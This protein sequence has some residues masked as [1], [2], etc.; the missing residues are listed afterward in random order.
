MAKENKA[1]INYFEVY[2][3]KK[4][5]KVRHLTGPSA[6]FERTV[7]EPIAKIWEARGQ[8]KIL[9]PAKVE[10]K[11]EPKPDKNE[12]LLRVA[13]ELGIKKADKMKEEELIE[14][15]ELAQAEK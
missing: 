4:L 8:V 3:S 9:G 5:M 1:D 13:A 12:E 14:A 15:I 7:K 10:P 6:G 11:P 2:D